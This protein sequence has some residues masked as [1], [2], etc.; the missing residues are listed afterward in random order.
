MFNRGRRGF[1]TAL[2]VVLGLAVTGSAAVVLT[3][4]GDDYRFFDPVI[5]VKRLIDQTYV[6]EVDQEALQRGAIR[7]MLEVL[8]DPY[9]EFIPPASSDDF[10]KEILGEYVGIGAQIEMVDGWLQIVS[11]LEDTPAFRMGL[12]AG[13][14][15]AEIDGVSTFGLSVDECIDRLTGGRG[16]PVRLTIE[17]GG[18]RLEI[19]IVRDQIK[20]L[21]VK[22]VHREGDD[23]SRW[24]F[25]LDPE[26]GI[27]Y[28]RLNQFTPGCAQEVLDALRSSGV[29]RGSLKGLILDLRWNPGGVLQEAIALAD[30][31]LEEGV[32][33]S[34]RGR[35][36]AEEVAS[37]RRPGTLP[38]FPMVVMLNENSASASEVLAG[39]LVENG[40]AVALGTRSYGKGS[41]QT[42][43]HLTS[44]QGAQI[45]LTQQGYFLPTGRSIQRH[46]DS[47]QWG[48][49]PTPGFFV[50]LTNEQ[51]V[52][53]FGVRRELEVIRGQAT[54]QPGEGEGD[55][56]ENGDW[57]V[58][59]LKDP[60]LA[61]ALQAVRLR[62][63]T[64]QWHPVGA[65]SPAG[66]EVALGE[67]VDTQALRDRL[68][69]ELVRID[70]RIATLSGAAGS[71]G[72]AERDLWSDDADLLGGHVV[73][74][75]AE[76]NEVSRL[77][78]TGSNVERWLID[79]DLVPEPAAQAPDAPATAAPPQP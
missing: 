29:Q 53:L 33:V 40:R 51:T 66:D 54:T 71:D 15:V 17:R 2:L 78:I 5:E 13:D 47:V 73:V 42:V 6:S 7:G 11:P 63:D 26:R 3:R 52:A 59:R 76:G 77:R 10:D 46:D 22:G 12:M 62:Q 70:R 49:D 41:V 34:T 19:T 79:A 75:D 61:A 60:Q 68:L 38:D 37:A 14:R 1:E 58:E 23:G 30:L 16:T 31:F 39:A 4:P 69:R 56:W 32:I 45:R 24:D 74:L 57:V 72:R 50:P 28:I 48:V 35:A 18:E 25:M 8:N 67:L 36:F 64:G 20:T 55:N 65:D 43:R 44:G 21:A 9:S 27:A